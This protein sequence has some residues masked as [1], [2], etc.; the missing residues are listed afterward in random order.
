MPQTSYCLSEC[1]E[2]G[3]SGQDVQPAGCPCFRMPCLLCLTRPH[4]RDAAAVDGGRIKSTEAV[5][6]GMTGRARAAGADR[7]HDRASTT[8]G[9]PDPART[10]QRQKSRTDTMCHENRIAR[11][12]RGPGPTSSGSSQ[13]CTAQSRAQLTWRDSKRQHAR[14]Q[15]VGASPGAGTGAQSAQTSAHAHQKIT[16]SPTEPSSGSGPMTACAPQGSAGVGRRGRRG[17]RGRAR[18]PTIRTVLTMMVT[19]MAKSKKGCSTKSRMVCAHR[20]TS[21]SASCS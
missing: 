11:S 7:M 14:L 3:T 2:C 19:M 6:R 9:G 8:E 10:A 17:R 13:M 16:A 20:S 15:A 1:G 5:P 4:V 18:A 12:A 21:S